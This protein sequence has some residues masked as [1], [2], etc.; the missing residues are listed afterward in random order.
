[1]SRTARTPLVTGLALLITSVLLQAPLVAAA[2]NAAAKNAATVARTVRDVKYLSS[3]ELEG[4][5]VGLKGLDKA[6]DY[7][8]QQFKQAGVDVSP[9]DGDAFQ[10]FTMTTGVKRGKTNTLQFVGPDGKTIPL[11]L[12]ADFQTCSFGG[13]AEIDA[14]MVFVGYA[15]E[16]EKLKFDELTGI[17]LKDK[18]AVV[19]RRVPKQGVK[20]GPFAGGHGG[21]SSHAELRTKMANVFGAGAKAIIFVNDEFSGKQAIER[22]KSSLHK[23][24]Q[25]FEKAE[26][27]LAEIDSGDSETKAE[28]E[29]KVE[30]AQKR[31]KR[32]A[33][34]VKTTETDQLMAF[35]YGRAGNPR[36]EAAYHVKRAAMDRVLKSALGTTLAE[37]EAGIDEDFKPRSALLRGWRAKGATTV[38][39][40]RTEVKNV[41]A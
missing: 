39:R 30:S 8:R 10:K 5:G 38:D 23:A 21:I 33:E 14:E 28:A 17:D 13:T 40:I 22:M 29:K 15:I 36:K 25:D 41:I 37:I 32:V 3:D 4:R 26:K 12:D 18:I 9:V 7:V 16:D 24:E 31:V 11:K 35:D 1:M 2:K 27:V 6:A 20:D 34:M 19:M